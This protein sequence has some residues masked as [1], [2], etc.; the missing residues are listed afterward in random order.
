MGKV[1]KNPEFRLKTN[2]E[3]EMIF[4]KVGIRTKAVSAGKIYEERRRVPEQ[5]TNF[6]TS[7][8]LPLMAGRTC[9]GTCLIRGSFF[10]IYLAFL[11]L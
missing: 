11:W 4:N 1:S 10:I 9:Y 5:V 7:P 2:S 8:P 3:R 6:L